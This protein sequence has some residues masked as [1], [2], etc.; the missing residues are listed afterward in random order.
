MSYLVEWQGGPCCYDDA[1]MK[2]C[3][4]EIAAAESNDG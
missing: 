4:R 2:D 1:L 3:V